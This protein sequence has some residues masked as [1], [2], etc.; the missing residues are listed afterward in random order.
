MSDQVPSFVLRSGGEDVA[1]GAMPRRLRLQYPDAIYHVMARGNGRQAIVRDDIDRDRLL[2]Q[3]GKAVV[4]CSWHVYAFVIMSNHLH[5]VLK[6]PQPN[7]SR[8]MQSFL[9]GYANK[10][11]RR[12]HFSGHVF[13]GRFRTELVEDE[14][15]LWTVTRYVHLNP[16]RAGIVENP[17]AWTWSSYSGYA[18]RA[19]RLEW[20]AYDELVASW[21][22][23]VW[24]P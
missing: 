17:G 15:Y 14:T 5:V 13:Q 10:W 19:R 22:R 2:E 3:L 24:W 23:R 21:S 8:G 11:S 16:V 6:T 18:H 1:I 12:H 9:S 4:R 7:L 20:V